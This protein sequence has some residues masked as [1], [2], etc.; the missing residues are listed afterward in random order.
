MYTHF[1]FKIKKAYTK[2]T[3]FLPSLLNNCNAVYCKHLRNTKW[4]AEMCKQMLKNVW[5]FAVFPLTSLHQMPLCLHQAQFI[6]F[7]S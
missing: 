7:L 5:L 4:G 2:I 6:L 3:Y 1:L